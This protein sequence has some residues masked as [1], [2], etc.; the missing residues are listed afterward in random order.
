VRQRAGD[1][2]DEDSQ[3]EKGLSISKGTLNILDLGRYKMRD[4][5]RKYVRTCAS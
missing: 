3:D 1:D 2:S 4:Q 5:E